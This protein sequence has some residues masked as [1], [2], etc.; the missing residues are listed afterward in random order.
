MY[1]LDTLKKEVEVVTTQTTLLL[2]YVIYLSYFVFVLGSILGSI[3][4]IS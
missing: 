1:V 4:T 2:I 3:C